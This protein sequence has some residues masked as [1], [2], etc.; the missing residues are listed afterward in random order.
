MI[1]FVSSFVYQNIDCNET[2]IDEI[3]SSKEL[4]YRKDLLGRTAQIN[5]KGFVFNVYK[6]GTVNK[7]YILHNK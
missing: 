5:K 3:N 7:Q 2:S 6:D 4:I 1:D